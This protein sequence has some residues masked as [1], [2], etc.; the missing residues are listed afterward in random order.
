MLEAEDPSP[1]NLKLDHGAGAPRSR[2]GDYSI[3]GASG[4]RQEAPVGRLSRCLVAL[5]SDCY[6]GNLKGA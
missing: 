5:G 2:G 6:N 1:R 4:N 3:Q